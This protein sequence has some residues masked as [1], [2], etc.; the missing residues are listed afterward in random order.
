MRDEGTHA[1]RVFWGRA[2]GGAEGRSTHADPA[3][4]G[5]DVAPPAPAPPPASDEG[6][7]L[8]EG[9]PP[10]LPLLPLPPLPLGLGLALEDQKADSLALVSSLGVAPPSPWLAPWGRAGSKAGLPPFSPASSAIAELFGAN[11]ARAL[12]KPF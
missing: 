4:S 7:G 5:S 10:A 12:L 8:G 1:I 9:A 3:E 6:V 11:C 2:G